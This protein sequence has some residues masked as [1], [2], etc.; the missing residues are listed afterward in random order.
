MNSNNIRECLESVMLIHG[1][2]GA[3]LVDWTTMRVVSVAEGSLDEVSRQASANSAVVVAKIR[4]MRQL[5]VRDRIEEFV[6]TFDSR[7]HVIRLAR[8]YPSYLFFLVLD[9]ASANLAMARMELANA[10]ETLVLGAECEDP[11]SDCDDEALT[12]RVSG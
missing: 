8:S 12:T 6:V 1:A 5:G 11:S 4:L 7:Y 9:R 3:A 2:L 10:E